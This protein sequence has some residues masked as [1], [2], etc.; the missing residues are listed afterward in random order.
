MGEV[1]RGGVGRRERGKG[2]RKQMEQGEEGKHH[3][4]NLDTHNKQLRVQRYDITEF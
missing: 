4:V 2:E 1:S 3:P